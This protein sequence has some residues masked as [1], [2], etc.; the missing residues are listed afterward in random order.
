MKRTILIITLFVFLGVVVAGIYQVATE[1]ERWA[2]FEACTDSLGGPTD[3][4]CE[5]CWHL[6]TGECVEVDFGKN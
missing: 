3:I 5:E 6:V 1:R 2:R 4:N